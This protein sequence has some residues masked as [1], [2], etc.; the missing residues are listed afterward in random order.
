MT[1]HLKPLISKLS[2]LEISEPP[3]PWRE[4]P[5]IAIGGVRSVG[6]Q[7]D[8]DLLLVVSEQGRGVIDCNT[9]KKLARDHDEY[10]EDEIRL[11]AEGIGP[12]SGQRIRISGLHG[13][14]LPNSTS[15]MWS[16]DAVTLA[17][18]EQLLILVEPGS[19]LYGGLYGKPDNLWKVFADSEIRAQGFSP[20]GRSLVIATSSEIQ[21][22]AREEM[23]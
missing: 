12:M 22:Y 11:E 6:F 3:P 10:F 18:P 1:D 16:L 5:A 9:G 7:P 2:L 21:I 20:T 14:G 19:W 4:V 17:W 23:G 8:S 15:D 13:G